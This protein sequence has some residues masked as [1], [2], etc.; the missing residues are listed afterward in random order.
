MRLK[1]VEIHGFRSIE[2][3][4]IPF[5]GNGHK[6]LVGKNESGKSNILN[7]LNLLSG[8]IAFDQKDEKEL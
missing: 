1:K 6:I 3:M 4:D 2:K 5:D 7:A 8:N